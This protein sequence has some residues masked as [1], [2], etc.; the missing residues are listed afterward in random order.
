M[1]VKRINYL[2]LLYRL[3]FH[4]NAKYLLIVVSIYHCCRSTILLELPSIK[5]HEEG[6]FPYFS[7][8]ENKTSNVHGIHIVCQVA[9]AGLIMKALSV[10]QEMKSVLGTIVNVEMF[11]ADIFET[12]LEMQNSAWVDSCDMT[13]SFSILVP[14]VASIGPDHALQEF[15]GID[16]V[17]IHC[18]S[19]NID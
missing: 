13:R 9:C 10:T 8:A 7:C 6:C 14:R 17:I 15:L 18:L 16:I 4:S 2:K 5:E 3:D 19:L 12:I 11:S 1:V